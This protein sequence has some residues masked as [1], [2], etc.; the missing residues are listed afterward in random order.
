MATYD[1]LIS[2]QKKRKAE[3]AKAKKAKNTTRVDQ[4]TRRLGE[5]DTGLKKYTTSEGRTA[6]IGSKVNQ[7][8]GSSTVDINKNYKDLYGKD[9][10]KAIASSNIYEGIVTPK[11]IQDTYSPLFAGMMGDAQGLRA[12]A[13]VRDPARDEILRT[14]MG[15]MDGFTPEQMQTMRESGSEQMNRALLTAQ[16]GANASGLASNINGGAAESLGYAPAR[17]FAEAQRGLQKDVFLANADEAF[18]NTGL[19]A[20]TAQGIDQDM[21][22]KK[23]SSFDKVA[24]LGQNMRSYDSWLQG[25]NNDSLTA[26][27]LGSFAA[28]S[29]GAGVG[30]SERAADRS[31]ELALKSI[32][33]MK[34]QPM[35]SMGAFGGGGGASDEFDDGASANSGGN[36]SPGG[37][38]LPGGTGGN[39]TTNSGGSRNNGTV[40]VT[41]FGNLGG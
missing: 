13:N 19:A 39:T 5:I 11:Q 34:A 16:R 31:Y 17:D 3:L 37:T 29:A 27:Q 28:G 23:M 15:R 10:G 35:P 6:D 14:I 20:Q 8:A 24:T 21:W 7:A 32:E 22:S 36:T 30:S 18:R 26:W 12:E 9:A 33:A 4:L 25:A 1:S 40:N 41:G 38:A 2:E